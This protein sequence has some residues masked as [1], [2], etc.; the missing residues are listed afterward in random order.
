MSNSISGDKSCKEVSPTTD[1][2]SLCIRNL[3]ENANLSPE[4][5]A[6]VIAAAN[7]SE[8]VVD[9]EFLKDMVPKKTLAMVSAANGSKQE[10]TNG[11]K[12]SETKQSETNTYAGDKTED[13]KP[14][15]IPV[16]LANKPSED[17]P[18]RTI[19]FPD[20]GLMRCF[21]DKEIASGRV[22]LYKWQAEI[23]DVFGSVKPTAQHPLKFCLVACNGS[24][25]DAFVIA[26]FVGWFALTK[27][28]SR[29]IITSSSGVQL[30][31]QTE[32]Y[33][34]SYCFRIN[35]YFG[36][37]IF[38]IRQR[39]ITCSLSGSEIRLFATDEE[40]KAEGYHPMDAGSEMAI[41][42]N[43]G[44][45]VSEDIHR[46]L[47]RCTGYNYWLEVSTPGEPSGFFYRAAKQW[48]FVK[49]VDYTQCPHLSR[50]EY[51][52]DLR[53]EGE[54]SSYFRSKWKALFTSIGGEVIIS[55]DLIDKLLDE[56][57]SIR[58]T[59][60]EKL[61]LR[62]GIDLAA[63][64][65]ENVIS[66]CCGNKCVK[67][68]YFREADTEITA[69]R[70]DLELS[71]AQI[72]KDHKHIYADDGGV[73]RAIIDKLVRRGWKINRILNQS[74]ATLA[75]VY[76]NK[77][78]ENWY[79][80]ARIFE[81]RL[82]D[83]TTI[84]EKTREQ[85]YTRHYKKGGT[86]GRIF[87]ESKKDAKLEGRLS[88]DRAD[89]LILAYTGLTIDDFLTNKKDSTE[90]KRPKER[91]TSQQALYEH[92]ENNVT[93][94]KYKKKPQGLKRKINGSLQ[95]AMAEQQTYA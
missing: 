59:S 11:S 43:E 87:L 14:L 81:E 15:E 77:G 71:R 20:P 61:G 26:S 55:K 92:Y 73:G 8:G 84:T 49:T 89:A 82:F 80:V 67:E 76:G 10:V 31:T 35:E 12:Q 46:A 28:R 85:L 7:I 27:V 50:D 54:H 30:T 75:K 39:Y 40:G 13:I 60:Y 68:I 19:D 91:F 17:S 74:Q 47:R 52:E 38:R 58:L 69:D 44:K 79:R 62:V 48:P 23:L 66:I 32:N 4:I 33:I 56:A 65:D 93:F 64:G 41:I 78:A 72:S 5:E 53:N 6:Q 29:C 37:E 1:A 34:R 36:C 45:S 2:K 83:V 18:W 16:E 57:T 90:D 94:E 25:K 88:P 9:D 3:I 22:N 86:G 24:G 51:E 95:V 21:F 70:I 63:G 42:V